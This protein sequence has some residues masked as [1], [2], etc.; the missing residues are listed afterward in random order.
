M[1]Y[2]WPIE[3]R[4]AKLLHKSFLTGSATCLAITMNWG[5]YSTYIPTPLS[6][7][8]WEE[9]GQ[10]GNQHITKNVKD[11]TVIQNIYLKDFLSNI[12]TNA[13]LTTYLAAKITDHSKGPTN[14]LKKPRATLVFY[15]PWLPQ[16]IRGGHFNP[17]AR[18]FN[19]Q[20]C[21]ACHSIDLQSLMF[22]LWWSKCIRAYPAT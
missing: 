2:P 19:W 17:V 14:K 7:N 18:P 3:W 10:R 9:N 11:T 1:Q 20:T 13:E 6:K 5:W 12:K 16:S 15:P 21:R 22:S 4:H 8:K